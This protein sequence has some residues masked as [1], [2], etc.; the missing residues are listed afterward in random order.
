MGI[1]YC[2]GER[3]RRAFLAG[4][5]WLSENKGILN[6]LNVFPVP[7]GDTGTNMSLTLAM[8]VD[9][10]RGMVGAPLE[11]VLDAIARGTLIGA[12][13]CS[14]VILSQLL[15]GF[16]G[17]GS[18]RGRFT[19][20][21]I[22]AG[23]QLGSKGAYQA[24]TKPVEGTILTVIRESSERAARFARDNEDIAELLGITLAEACKSLKNSPTLLPILAQAGV[25]DAGGQGFVHMLEGIVRLL[26]GDTLKAPHQA[27]ESTGLGAVQARVPQ[28]WDNPYCT[29]FLLQKND[30]YI[31]DIRES[32]AGLGEE[33]V[34]VGW[35]EMVRV[36]IHTDD[37]E[38]ALACAHS[39]G[40][41]SNVKID[42]TRKQHKHIV[43][44]PLKAMTAE[45]ER[46]GSIVATASGDGLK[47][48]CMSLGAESVVVGN[49]SRNPSVLE[50]IHAVE[51]AYSDNV[52]LLAND[53]NAIPAAM[54][55]AG[56]SCKQVRVIPSRNISQ[57]F[58]AL[59]A[60]RPDANLDDNVRNME[61]A[62]AE[63]KHGEVA[64]AARNAQFGDLVIK[65]NDVIGLFDGNVQVAVDSH[66][67]AVLELLKI[68][69]EEEN[70][71]ISIFYGDEIQRTE[72]EQVLGEVESA[73]PDR[74]PELHYGG[75]SY[76]SYILSVE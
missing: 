32:F 65:G 28:T 9:E 51:R 34:V 4:A 10:L 22:A 18:N 74:D 5:D 63:V 45:E 29:E 68:M 58:S 33:L 19:S 14:G 25:V 44:A 40:K 13:G 1:L 36:H 15:A 70:E 48:I 24:V 49:E 46:E 55:A 76:C 64:Q 62:L 66:T 71:I 3:F 73:F 6:R 2:D 57:G 26:R 75:Q 17:L 20:K 31:P 23:L 50:L 60:F 67:T 54:R 21:D 11:E 8:A 38:R 7:D 52:L 12:R 16:A 53:S 41:P 42:D 72:A 37:P 30:A 39:H 69:V 43:Q 27:S 59:I 56:M 35:G 47:A 61:K